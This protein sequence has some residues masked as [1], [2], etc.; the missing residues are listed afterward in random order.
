MKIAFVD[1]SGIDFNPLT[2]ETQP[3]G[4]MQSGVCY[5]ARELQKRGHD[6][7]IFNGSSTEG[8][9][10]GVRLVNFRRHF[11]AAR[12]DCDAYIS[13]SCAGLTLR[14]FTR[15][16]PLILFTGHSSLERS[17]QA[18]GRPEERDCW[19][20]FVFKSNWQA[21]AMRTTFALDPGR[22]SIITNAVSPAFEALPERTSFPFLEGRPPVFY[23]SSTPFRGLDILAEA[24]PTIARALPGARAR[25]YSSMAPYQSHE[26]ETEFGGLYRA[27]QAA[28]MDYIGSL[29]Q[30]ELA[31]AVASADALAFP[32]TYAET[33]C[34]TLMEAMAGSTLILSR[35]LGAIPETAAGFGYLLPEPAKLRRPAL[36]AAFAGLVIRTLKS[37]QARPRQAAARLRLQRRYC[38]ANYSWPSKAKEWE[39]TLAEI[40]ARV[41]VRK[42]GVT[43]PGPAEVYNYVQTLGGNKLY[44]DPRD[45]RAR[46]LM[47][48]RGVLNPETNRLWKVAL[49]LAPWSV[50]VDVGAN[51][52]EMLL[53]G[54]VTAYSRVIAVEPSP[55]ILPR[56]RKTVA[57]FPNVEVVAAALAESEGERRFTENFD[58]S[59][60]SRLGDG[61]NAVDVKTTTLDE[62]L[63][64]EGR[65]EGGALRLL[66]KIDVEGGE[67][68]VLR[69]GALSIARA[70]AFCGLIEVSNLPPEEAARLERRF[71]I[72]ALDVRQNKVARVASFAQ[73]QS[74]PHYWKQDALILRKSGQ[75]AAPMSLEQAFM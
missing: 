68:A 57:H 41:A 55:R 47:V 12:H 61:P 32:S 36:A 2:P 69:G 62:L 53:D 74:T 9:F 44:L 37:A 17:M 25:V 59:G 58:W 1:L 26:R 66:L 75:G 34:I 67:P 71:D 63:A 31:M 18:L 42:S 11:S 38:L 16:K 10:D 5:L 56:L 33:S 20:H 27:C 39:A 40:A 72:Y 51:Y 45:G 15:G 54:G 60:M 50:I 65:D 52:G 73:L 24:F 35:A 29:S 46:R 6:V 7:L 43:P 23:F 3:L 22:I 28:G 14:P 8:E 70:S 30:P 13:I 64:R 4:G 21:E 49:Q 48:R 19:D